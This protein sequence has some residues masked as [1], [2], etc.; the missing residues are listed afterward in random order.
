LA[1]LSGSFAATPNTTAE[2]L[3]NTKRQQTE[4][5]EPNRKYQLLQH[6]RVN[7]PLMCCLAGSPST[8]SEALVEKEAV[9]EGER[10]GEL[11][12]WGR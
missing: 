4:K 2:P 8:N 3:F 9:R 12:K 11:S 1:A 10:E 7:L 5:I 6:L